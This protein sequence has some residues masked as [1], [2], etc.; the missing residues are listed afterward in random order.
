ME[1]SSVIRLP[2]PLHRPH[3]LC[4]YFFMKI[5]LIVCLNLFVLSYSWAKAVPG[6]YATYRGKL[7]GK[8]YKLYR[9]EVLRFSEA[10]YD[11][12]YKI[13]EVFEDGSTQES[14][15][16]KPL[17]DDNI[18][19]TIEKK[20]EQYGERIIFTMP[21]SSATIPSCR[22]RDTNVHELFIDAANVPFGFT[23][24]EDPD[25]SYLE[26]VDFKKF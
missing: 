4:Q 3:F 21:E 12:E 20:C 7:N 8:T 26:L 22:L 16:T 15:E 5:T 17:M 6:D 24:F 9:T 18:G 1:S 13:T 10:T 23:Y 25:G 2:P 11:T 19:N 14:T